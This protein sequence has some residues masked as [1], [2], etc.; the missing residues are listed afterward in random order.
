MWKGRIFSW[1]VGAGALALVAGLL[2]WGHQSQASSDNY[3]FLV[4]GIVTEVSHPA[5]TVR[6]YATYTSAAGEGDLAG[7]ELDYD[8]HGAVFY[9]WQNSKK[10][11][12]TFTKS[13]QVGD[14]IVM[15]G[16]KKGDRLSVAWLVVNDRSFDMQG[17]L[18]DYDQDHMLMKLSVSS[19]TFKAERYVGKDVTVS[20]RD[21][22]PFYARSGGEMEHDT[23]SADAQKVRIVG[24]MEGDVLKVYKFYNEV[25]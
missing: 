14:E 8:V 25:K 18:I 3:V 9:K 13:A 19:S 17:N 11:K 6:M 15:K 2:T 10:N 23:L 7:K 21:N 1:A 16:T 24:K 12:V 22:T 20:Y 4:R 5:N